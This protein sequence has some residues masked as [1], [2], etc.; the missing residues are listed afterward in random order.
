M[1]LET[2]LETLSHTL[3]QAT[4]ALSLAHDIRSTLTEG[5]AFPRKA[6]GAHDIQSAL[7]PVGPTALP[8]TPWRRFRKF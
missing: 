7:G 4:S 5:L 2:V 6:I 8:E 3:A 1:T